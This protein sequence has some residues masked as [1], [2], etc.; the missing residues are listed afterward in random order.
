MQHL[1]AVMLDVHSPFVERAAAGSAINQYGDPR[2]GVNLRADGLPDIAWCEVPAGSFTMGSDKDA[3]NPTRIKTLPT[4]YIAKYP[5][6]Y[7]QFQAFIDAPDGYRNAVWWHGLHLKGQK[8]QRVSA[9]EQRWKFDNHPRDRVSW[10]DAMA[11][12]RWL[13]TKLKYVVQLPTEEEWEKAARGTDGRDYPYGCEF[14]SSKGNTFEMGLRQTSAVGIFLEGASPYNVL[15]MSGN[16][17]EWTLTEF[18]TH[19]NS[20][21]S[22]S[23]ARVLRGGSWDYNFYSARATSRLKNF[24]YARD[25]YNG[26]RVVTMATEK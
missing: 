21:F 12:C 5:I 11:F 13:S 16:V 7:K 15:D 1:L 20:D 25:T 17:W 14:D 24:L 26:F 19:N 2:L 8:Q 10:Y 6:T 18:D 22:N 4:F 3:D 9:K 23:N